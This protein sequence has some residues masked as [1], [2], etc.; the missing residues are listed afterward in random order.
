M[1]QPPWLADAF[2]QAEA[3]RGG[4]MPH[5]LLVQGP[6]GWGEELVANAL[7]AKMLGLD[8]GDDMREVAHPDL[9]WRESEDGFLKIDAVRQVIEFL[10]Q[11]PQLAT[12]KVAVFRDAERMNAN[13]A[14]A[15][16]KTLEEPPAESFLVLTSGAPERLLPTVRSRCQR[17]ALRGADTASALAWLAEMGVDVEAARY[18][19]VEYGGAPFAVLAAAQREQP[20]LWQT[21]AAAG[22]AATTATDLAEK[23]R[24]EDL[25]DLCAR[26]Q[27]IVHWLAR[28]T[29]SASAALLEFSAE[30]LEVRRAALFNTGLNRPMQIERLLLLWADVFKRLPDSEEPRAAWS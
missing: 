1:N 22:R 7:A 19:V 3:L 4:R 18:F 23:R 15:L 30:L 20:P 16:L 28:R 27:R 21:L 2:A 5:A 9:R 17:I 24:D 12:R 25:A 29:P 14:N 26:W 8:P 13:A 6:A 11:T 10:M